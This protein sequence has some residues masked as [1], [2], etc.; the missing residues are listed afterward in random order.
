MAIYDLKRCSVERF[1][2]PPS[3]YGDMHPHAPKRRD[4]LTMRTYIVVL[5]VIFVSSYSQYLVSGVSLV[6]GASCVYA[7]SILVIL[8]ISGKS[9]FRKAFRHNWSA[10]RL[11]LGFFGIFTLLSAAASFLI[12]L[13][14]RDLDPSALELRKKP[15]PVLHDP[16]KFAWVMV[17]ASIVA[18]GPCEEFIFRGFV[19]GGL[20]RLFGP[21]HWLALAFASSVLF[22]VAHLYYV[23]TYGVASLIPFVNI[24]AIGMALAIAYYRSGGNLLVP[25]LIH[26]VFDATGFMAVAVMSVH[27]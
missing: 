14:L 11:G 23:L 17:W 8:S 13:A 18:V 7:I 21:R 26:G 25:D 2:D 10:L 4:G 16:Q 1:V 24:V 27:R 15:V 6:L 22:A 9:I 12:A 3:F 20:L 19:F 5:L